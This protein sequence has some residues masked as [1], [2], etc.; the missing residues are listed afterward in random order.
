M[1]IAVILN[2][3]EYFSFF[4]IHDNRNKY[5]FIT[6]KNKFK[7]RIKGINFIDYHNYKNSSKKQNKK[8]QF[9]FLHAL[10]LQAIDK[11]INLDQISNFFELVFK[12]FYKKN[13]IDFVISGAATGF[14]RCGMETAKSL[15]IKT[16]YVWEGYLRPNTISVDPKGMNAEGSLYNI[17]LKKIEN[18]NISE[19]FDYYFNSYKIATTPRKISL[20][21]I[22]KGKFNIFSQFRNRYQD[23]NDFERIRLDMIHLLF[24][25]LKYYQYKYKDKIDFQNKYIFFPLQ[26]HTDSN[27]VINSNHYP[28]KKFVYQIISEFLETKYLSN[29]KLV[30]KEHPFDVYRIHYNKGE[31]DRILWMHPALPTS[32]FLKDKNCLGT[33]VVNSTVGLESLIFGKPV[34][35]FGKAVY[36][37]HNLT[38]NYDTHANFEDSI[39]KLLNSKVNNEF[40]RKYLG[41]LF[42]YH[43]A[44]GN[45]NKVPAK[46]EVKY[47]L[48]KFIEQKE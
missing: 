39:R 19:E 25:R 24:A 46:W 17:N 34:L 32:L 28:Y 10:K 42:D 35:C 13:N 33:I 29:L 16:L 8:K 27:I 43:Q 36:S 2:H 23:R 21:T 3:F 15:G 41:Y 40:L 48:N 14:E 4:Q 11:N 20:R 47:F 18:H 45:L 31:Y 5:F 38:I 12:D 30:I 7:N 44:L 37:Q 9:Y 6:N 1:N 22:Q 26:T